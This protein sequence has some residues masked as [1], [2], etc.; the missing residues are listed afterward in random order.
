[1]KN[2]LSGNEARG[3]MKILVDAKTDKVIGVH[4]IGPDCAEIMQ[5]SYFLY[6]ES[7]VKL[8]CQKSFFTHVDFDCMILKMHLIATALP[9][10]SS[11]PCS[12]LPAHMVSH[13]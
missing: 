2:T 4:M 9:F 7:A 12:P 8:A 11:L 10:T 13:F 1:M 6:A 3:F 5:V